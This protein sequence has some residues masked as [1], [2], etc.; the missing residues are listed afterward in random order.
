MISDTAAAAAAGPSLDIQDNEEG[1]H[2]YGSGDDSVTF[3]PISSFIR[4]GS[5]FLEDADIA[6]DTS[7]THSLDA[8]Q[9]KGNQLGKLHSLYVFRSFRC[10]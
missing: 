7:D 10:V 9:V 5:V 2:E 6:D 8:Q 1:E 3:Q 4:N